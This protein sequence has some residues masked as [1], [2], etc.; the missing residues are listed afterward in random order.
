MLWPQ[1]I[2]DRTL[3][4]LESSLG[5]YAAA[6]QLQ[7]RPMPKGG[8]ILK[9]EWWVPWEHNTLPDVEYVLQLEVGGGI[10][11][12]LTQPIMVET[13][14]SLFNHAK[15]VFTDE[16]GMAPWL[17]NEEDLKNDLMLE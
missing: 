5:S 9:A 14:K 13:V 16:E 17:K 2:D 7:Q 3:S 6:G 1:R 12:F 15:K 8:G 4:N 11:Q 10:P